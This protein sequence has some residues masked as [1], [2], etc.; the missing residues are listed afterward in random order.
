MVNTTR[1]IL[2]AIEEVSQRIVN[3]Y[4]HK[5]VARECLHLGWYEAA[6]WID[7]NPLHYSQLLFEGGIISDRPDYDPG[8][9]YF[10]DW[11]DKKEE[12][13]NG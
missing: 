9:M 12:N 3:L 2:A 4:D 7:R 1:D 6:M 5:A 13:T 11:V 8:E 10:W